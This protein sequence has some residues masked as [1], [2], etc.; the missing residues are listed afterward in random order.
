MPHVNRDGLGN[1]IRHFNQKIHN[2][3]GFGKSKEHF[4]GHRSSLDRE[5]RHQIDEIS[6]LDQ[7]LAKDWIDSNK[8][9]EE[10]ECSLR[11]DKLPPEGVDADQIY[12]NRTWDKVLCWP[13]TPAGTTA[14]LPCFEEFN[15]IKYDTSGKIF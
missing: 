3:N 9:F 15:G 11:P 8:T 2:D 12:C 10:L 14:V 6:L 4:T 5:R 1:V 7:K 13:P